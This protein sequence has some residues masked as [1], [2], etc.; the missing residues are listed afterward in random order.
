[1]S[2]FPSLSFPSPV[3]WQNGRARPSSKGLGGGRGRGRYT[4]LDIN[5]M[6]AIPL[7]SDEKGVASA[8]EDEEDESEEAEVTVWQRLGGR[9]RW[10]QRMRS[11][12]TLIG[13]ICG[14]GWQVMFKK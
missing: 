5:D 13:L 8:E 9:R 3:K 2:E 6:D 10:Q 12:S 11:H 4:S 1:M 7:T 14:G